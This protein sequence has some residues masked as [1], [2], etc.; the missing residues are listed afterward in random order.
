MRRQW[1]ATEALALGWGGVSTVAVA[2]GLARNTVLA[3]MREVGHRR[4]YPRTKI[5]KRIRSEGGGRKPLI[6]TDP[7]L[8]KALETLVD[9]ATRGHPQSPLRWTCKSTAKLAEELNKQQHPVTDRTVAMLL[10]TGV[11]RFPKAT[12]LLIT[13]DGGG[14]SGS[15]NRL[16][17]VALQSPADDLALQ[18]Q[19]CHIRLICS[20]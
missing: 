19:V 7:G 13:T 14:R 11:Q 3:G 16:W 1:A 9:P 5:S 2:T 8:Q 18:L 10:K 12:T 17:K 15:R 4:R 20:T 6:Q